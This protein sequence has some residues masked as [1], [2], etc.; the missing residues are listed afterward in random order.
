VPVKLP[1]LE[2]F[3]SAGYL[4]QNSKELKGRRNAT[5]VHRGQ[6]EIDFKRDVRSCA[7]VEDVAQHV[8]YYARRGAI[9]P[10]NLL[11]RF[12]NKNYNT[13]FATRRTMQL[14]AQ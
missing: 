4:L 5:H 1:W 10:G 9:E 13:E 6:P 12:D 8:R 11:N 3:T 7:P 2:A 14:T